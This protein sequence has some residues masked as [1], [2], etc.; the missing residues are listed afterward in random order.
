MFNKYFLATLLVL[1]P[2]TA[3]NANPFSELANLAGENKGLVLFMGSSAALYG[4]ALKEIT[5]NAPSMADRVAFGA[6]MTAGLP[7][8]AYCMD[9]IAGLNR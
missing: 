7:L 9:Y 6:I 5:K 4:Y 2:V 1:S 3:I 8:L